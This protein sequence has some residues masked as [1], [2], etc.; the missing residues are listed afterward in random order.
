MT[1]KKNLIT[2]NVSGSFSVMTDKEIFEAQLPGVEVDSTLKV[3]GVNGGSSF[4]CSLAF[5]IENKTYDLSDSAGPIQMTYLYAPSGSDVVIMRA[6]SGKAEVLWDRIANNLSVSFSCARSGIP[7]FTAQDGTLTLDTSNL[8]ALPESDGM[9]ATTS[10]GPFVAKVGSLISEGRIVVGGGTESIS[11]GLG[12]YI[13]ISFPEKLAVGTYTVGSPEFADIKMQCIVG[14]GGLKDA[15]SG[16]FEYIEHDLVKKSTRAAFTFETNE[17]KIWDGHYSAGYESNLLR[18]ARRGTPY[19]LTGSFSG[20]INGQAEQSKNMLSMQNEY[21]WDISVFFSTETLT[22]S[23][24]LNSSVGSTPIVAP[25][26]QG[27]HLVYSAGQAHATSGQL[28]ISRIGWGPNLALNA[29]FDCRNDN[30]EPALT[31]QQASIEI[32]GPAHP[33]YV[34]ATINGQPFQ[35]TTFEVLDVFGSTLFGYAEDS[36]FV[37]ITLDQSLL[38]GTYTLPDARITISYHPAGGARIVA[39]TGICVLA[40][41]LDKGYLSGSFNFDNDGYSVTGGQFSFVKVRRM[42]KG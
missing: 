41:E 36:S 42:T 17:I 20:V 3:F 13:L 23:I 10:L 12:N 38:A 34:T 30:I 6:D 31:I 16:S 35:A 14:S 1:I 33:T 37:S 22:L 5:D 28:E 11:G 15:T 40:S 27:A 32:V 9:T 8:P 18:N 25:D 26:K 21:Y 24:P 29:T 2:P 7:G 19:L 4:F 39:K